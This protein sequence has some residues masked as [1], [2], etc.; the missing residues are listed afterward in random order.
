MQTYCCLY[1]ECNVLFSEISEGYVTFERRALT[2]G[3]EVNWE[4][5]VAAFTNLRVMSHGK[6][7]TEGAGMLQVVCVGAAHITEKNNCQKFLANLLINR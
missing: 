1:V 2:E 5:S 4:K 3:R 7:E 6:I